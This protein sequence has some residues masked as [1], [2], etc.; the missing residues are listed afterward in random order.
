MSGLG[1]DLWSS[2]D[3]EARAARIA[4]SSMKETNNALAQYINGLRRVLQ[5]DPY[6]GMPAA[7]Q[8]AL[9]EELARVAEALKSD[10]QARSAAV[11][12]YGEPVLSLLAETNESARVPYG[13]MVEKWGVSDELT[14]T[15]KEFLREALIDFA[16]HGGGAAYWILPKGTL[17]LARC[18]VD[19]P[20]PD[21]PAVRDSDV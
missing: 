5:G 11:D 2:T 16:P 13:D 3:P 6:A 18:A 10:A 1:P 14:S 7:R 8:L 19:A 15:L 4:L 12:K 21:R 20:P 9:A 17:T